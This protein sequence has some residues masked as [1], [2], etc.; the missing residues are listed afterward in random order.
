MG[1]S[2][3][4]D[5]WLWTVRIYKTRSIATEEC[6][7]GRVTMNGMP[8]KPSREIKPGDIIDVRKPPVNYKFKVKQ[9]P[10]NRLGAKLVPDYLEDLT[11]KEE[12]EALEM[13]KYMQWNDREK[14]MGRP[15][16]KERRD[17]DDFLDW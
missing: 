3:R 8:V 7:K 2:N 1:D 9:M 12:L 17:L 11:P 5:K 13:Q 16:K 15:T 10:S 4:I 14:G 6:K